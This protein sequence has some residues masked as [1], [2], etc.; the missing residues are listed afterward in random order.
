MIVFYYDG[1]VLIIVVGLFVVVLSHVKK[2]FRN[3]NLF[4]FTGL[5]FQAHV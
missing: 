2:S 4:N 1:H 3:L 5:P